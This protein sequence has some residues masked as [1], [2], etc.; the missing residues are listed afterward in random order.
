MKSKAEE[1]LASADHWDQLA[2]EAKAFAEYEREIGIC[3]KGIPNAYDHKAATYI[4]C[5]KS[6]RLQAETGTPHC[7]CHL[8]ALD[9]CPSNPRNKSYY[10]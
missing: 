1:A 9:R 3:P 7:S 4:E 5:A 2:K 10:R 8:V 6:L